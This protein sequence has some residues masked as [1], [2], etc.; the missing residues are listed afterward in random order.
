ME[1]YPVNSGQNSCVQIQGNVECNVSI[2]YIEKPCSHQLEYTKV[3]EYR[4]DCPM[5]T[6]NTL[7]LV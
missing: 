6:H 2:F 5:F 3:Q 1:N 7:L 4:G